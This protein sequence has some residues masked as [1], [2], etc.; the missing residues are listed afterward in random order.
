MN[1]QKKKI[2]IDY[3]LKNGIVLEWF[4]LSLRVLWLFE[5]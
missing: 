3:D 1:R 2:Q 5:K 4:V